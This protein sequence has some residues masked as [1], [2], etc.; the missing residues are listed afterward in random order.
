MSQMSG[1]VA[2]DG[3]SA[4]RDDATLVDLLSAPVRARSLRRCVTAGESIVREGEEGASAFILL[5]GECDVSVHGDVLSR[6]MPGEVFGE[7]ACLERGTRTATVKARADSEILEIS[8]DDLRA[9][10]RQSPVLLDRFLRA[11]VYRVRSISRR[12][13][14]R[15]ET[16]IDNCDAY[17]STCCHL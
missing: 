14:R 17:W 2:A 10:L 4:R 1:M 13:Q 12:E 8:V 6:V 9:E 16:S 7:I 3:G 11:I 5:S 15:D